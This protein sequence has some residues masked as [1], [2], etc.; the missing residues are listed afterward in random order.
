[1]S[2]ETDNQNHGAVGLDIGT[3]RIVVAERA[4]DEFRFHSQLNAFVNVPFSKF[5]QA[6]FQKQRMAH[7]VAAGDMLVLGDEA[8]KLANVLNRETRRPMIRGLLNPEEPDNLKVITQMVSTMVNGKARSR[9]VCFSVPGPLPGGSD[10]L[11]YH[12]AALKEALSGLGWEATSIN[13]GLAVVLAELESS[14]Y[15]GIGISCG[16]GMCNVCLAYLSIPL[17]SFSIPKAGD[18]ID[19]SVASVTGETATRVRTLKESGFHFNGH[20]SDKVQQAIGVYYDDMIRSL[21]TGLKEALARSKNVPRMDRP[22]PLV[23]SGG[24][25]LP[26]GFRDRFERVLKQAELSLPI[27]EVRLSSDPLHSTAKGALVAALAEV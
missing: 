12:E 21:V 18:F 26:D 19:S 2:K 25:A 6:V 4:E 27:S 5:T 23:I 22:I 24:S 9:R 20:C 8:E 11:T 17:L 15:T 13:E 1:M 7:S 14:S 10:E 3:S 16:G